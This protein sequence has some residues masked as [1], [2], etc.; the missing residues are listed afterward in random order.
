MPASQRRSSL[1]SPKRWPRA[2]PCANGSK[3]CCRRP[4]AS[5]GR[6]RPRRRLRMIWL[7]RWRRRAPSGASCRRRLIRSSA[8]CRRGSRRRSARSSTAVRTRSAALTWI[9]NVIWPRSRD[10]AN[11]SRPLLGAA[12]PGVADARSPAEVLAERLREAL[13]S[14][15]MGA[16][17]DPQAQ[18]RADMEEVKRLQAER[19]AIGVVPGETGRA[20]SNRFHAACD[21]FFQQQPPAPERP[22]RPTGES[23]SGRGRPG[24]RQD[25]G[26]RRRA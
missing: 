24:S 10:C 12:A 25:S 19:R 17:V 26:S 16:R 9:R 15:T 11:G 18:R 23:R 21:R 8:V 6:N 20:L 5:R 1:N 2:L 3:R 4:R 7:G 13:A 22:P 14:N